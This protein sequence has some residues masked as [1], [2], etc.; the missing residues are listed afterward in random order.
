VVQQPNRQ[1]SRSHTL[2]CLVAIFSA[3]Q[4]ALRSRRYR[5]QFAAFQA[6]AG[7]I[8]NVYVDSLPFQQRQ[9]GLFDAL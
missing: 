5:L 7:N 1:T 4:T 9:I 3:F 6:F 2:V 8:G